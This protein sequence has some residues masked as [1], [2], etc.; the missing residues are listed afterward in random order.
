MRL[1]YDLCLFSANYSETNKEIHFDQW[2]SDRHKASIVPIVIVVIVPIVELSRFR[3]SSIQCFHAINRLNRLRIGFVPINL[4]SASLSPHLSHSVAPSL[5]PLV[6]APIWVFHFT[7]ASY[8]KVIFSHRGVVISHHHVPLAC[9]HRLC[10]PYNRR[11]AHHN[12]YAHIWYLNRSMG[13]RWII[14]SKRDQTTTKKKKKK[15][16]QRRSVR[17]LYSECNK[18]NIEKEAKIEKR[19]KKNDTDTD[20]TLESYVNVNCEQMRDPNR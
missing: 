2:S 17:T 1:V 3:Y 18:I 15:K 20:A 6:S 13:H 19:R 7:L 5:S 8:L 14:Q 4:I 10:S 11:H 9:A 16:K 12:C